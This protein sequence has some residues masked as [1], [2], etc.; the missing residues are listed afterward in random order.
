MSEYEALIETIMREGEKQVQ[1]I[2]D[3]ARREA[4]KIVKEAERK[5][6][7]IA[8]KEARI[9]RETMLNKMIDEKKRRLIE[10]KIK[11]KEAKLKQ[12]R[13][14]LIRRIQDIIHG[15]DRRWDYTKILY[16]LLREAVSETAQEKVVVYANG[17]DLEF[18]KTHKAELESRLEED[19]GKKIT[20]TIGDKVDVIGGVICS[21]PDGVLTYNATIDGRIDEV[22]RKLSVKIA[23]NLGMM[24]QARF[25]S[26]ICKILE[27]VNKEIMVKDAQ[28]RELKLLP[29]VEVYSL[30]M[31]GQRIDAVCTHSDGK[32]TFIYAT[33]GTANVK[34]IDE[35]KSSVDRFLSEN[36]VDL[37]ALI[38]IGFSGV[39]EKNVREMLAKYGIYLMTKKELIKLANE[40]GVEF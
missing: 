19:L 21:T 32:T 6:Y 35:F 1:E 38:F 20:L 23:R 8:E 9:I 33:L 2:L 26:L 28:G 12:L 36:K 14:I 7:E 24:S 17:R 13:T 5:A 40:V 4:E 11:L 30:I 29:V 3:N 34:R 18:I 37:H 25:R 16:S 15:K 39:E 27:R 31:P 22:M 10:D